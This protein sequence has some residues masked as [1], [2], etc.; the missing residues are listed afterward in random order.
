MRLQ[1]PRELFC[2][3]CKKPFKPLGMG[4]RMDCTVDKRYK[5]PQLITTGH[6]VLI[7]GSRDMPFS[8]WDAL[9][10]ALGQQ[11]ATNP[12]LALI[13]GGAR[14][15]D[16]LGVRWAMDSGVALE[17][18]PAQYS[19]LPP[20]IAPLWRN[21]EMAHRLPQE[22]LGFIG[23]CTKADH[24][25]TPPHASHGSVDMALRLRALGVPVIPHTWG[26]P[27]RLEDFLGSKVE[28]G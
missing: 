5:L 22:G 3:E 23:P 14:G 26:F 17:G 19:V 27:G 1:L 20:G 9:E 4:H 24:R 2:P 18:W 6:K 15:A 25:H 7:F 16:Q 10:H 28:G 21:A 13:H 8:Q 12:D 11:L